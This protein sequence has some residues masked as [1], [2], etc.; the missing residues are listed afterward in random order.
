MKAEAP[1][2]VLPLGGGRAGMAGGMEGGGHL[3][4]ALRGLTDC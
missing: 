2:S 1:G 3:T 4:P